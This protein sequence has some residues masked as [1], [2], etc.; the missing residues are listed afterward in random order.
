M[1]EGKNGK[2]C[3]N[4]G[5]CE[6]LTFGTEDTT[7]RIVKNVC[8]CKPGYQGLAC[9]VAIFH[10]DVSI[11]V[12]YTPRCFCDKGWG[13]DGCSESICPTSNCS[14]H[15]VCRDKDGEKVCYCEP[16]YYGEGCEYSYDHRR[17][18]LVSKVCFGHGICGV[19]QVQNNDTLCT[20]KIKR[21]AENATQVQVYAKTAQ[22]KD[23][24]IRHVSSLIVVKTKNDVR[25][26]TLSQMSRL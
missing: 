14:G 19:D 22:L 26:N 1:P 18:D 12:I 7:A 23:S 10:A 20:V 8:Y 24:V 11:K 13:G 25:G 2:I 16:M 6:E 4:N 15:G 5:Q 17:C 21:M 9:G 3:S